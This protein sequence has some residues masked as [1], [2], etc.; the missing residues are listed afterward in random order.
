M[1]SGWAAFLGAI[2]GGLLIMLSD[3]LR[4]RRLRRERVQDTLIAKRIAVYEE[5]AKRLSELWWSVSLRQDGLEV[6]RWPKDR[7][8]SPQFFA[9]GEKVPPDLERQKTL[10]EKTHERLDGLK[11]FA[12]AHAL[13]LAP[14]VQYVFWE[15]LGELDEWRIHLKVRTDGQLSEFGPRP[16]RAIDKALDE[17]RSRTVRAMT[18][19]LGVSGFEVPDLARLEQARRVGAAKVTGLLRDSKREGREADALHHE[20]GQHGKKGN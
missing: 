15:A 1:S 6:L 2:V 7:R 3:Y 11:E 13:V 14:G 4:H 19:D 10:A 16:S 20:G 9:E 12:H 5:L 18:Q 17:L 8:T